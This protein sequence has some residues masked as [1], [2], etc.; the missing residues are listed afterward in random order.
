MHSVEIVTAHALPPKYDEA[1]VL[2]EAL[3]GS[4]NKSS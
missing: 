1:C 4:Y 3:R 2:S